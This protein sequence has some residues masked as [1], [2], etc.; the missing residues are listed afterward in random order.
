[1]LLRSVPCQARLC[2]ICQAPSTPDYPRVHTAHKRLLALLCVGAG[3]RLMGDQ[4]VVGGGGVQSY[5]Q[6]HERHIYANGAAIR[7]VA[8]KARKGGGEG[9]VC[10][11][12]HTLRAHPRAA[13]RHSLRQHCMWCCQRCHCPITWLRCRT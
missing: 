9:A 5:R 2:R 10:A 13:R 3:L 1:M 6:L 7:C 11:A 4:D 12:S 8:W